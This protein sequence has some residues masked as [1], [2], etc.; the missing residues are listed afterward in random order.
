[1]M[2]PGTRRH[3]KSPRRVNPSVTAGLRCAP[4]TAPMKRMIPITISPGAAT[5]VDLLIAPWLVAFTTAPPAPTRTRKNVPR[6]SEKSRRHSSLGSSKSPRPGYS[7]ASSDRR[8]V[9]VFDLPSWSST[10]SLT[11][12]KLQQERSDNRCYRIDTHRP[13]RVKAA[14]EA[15]IHPDGRMRPPE[16]EGKLLQWQA[17][18]E[19]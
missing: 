7:R 10:T 9:G 14:L 4:E 17:K 12:S 19:A 16:P 3:G 13:D 1:M 6:S 15:T 8:V 2:Y 18:G 5:A 11:P